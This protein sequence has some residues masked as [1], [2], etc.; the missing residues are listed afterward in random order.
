MPTALSLTERRSLNK[1]SQPLLNIDS[2]DPNQPAPN[3]RELKMLM[4]LLRKVRFSPQSRRDPRDY[5]FVDDT[6]LHIYNTIEVH[7]CD[8]PDRQIPVYLTPN[9]KILRESNTINEQPVSCNLRLCELLDEVLRRVD[10]ILIILRSRMDHSYYPFDILMKKLRELL[11]LLDYS[12][13]EMAHRG[14]RPLHWLIDLI[15]HLHHTLNILNSGR[16]I[17]EY[18]LERFLHHLSHLYEEL[19]S[20][21]REL[22]CEEIDLSHRVK[23]ADVEDDNDKTIEDIATDPNRKRILET[24]TVLGQYVRPIDGTPPRIE[25]DMRK[26]N[27]LAIRDNV[28]LYYVIEVVFFHEM[29]HAL[30]DRFPYT[31]TDQYIREIDEPI[32][33]YGMLCIMSKQKDAM[34]MDYAEKFVYNK[35]FNGPYCYSLGWE[36]FTHIDKINAIKRR[37]SA[38]TLLAYYKNALNINR[39]SYRLA[40]YRDSFRLGF[41]QGHDLTLCLKRLMLLIGHPDY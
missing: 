23:D 25:L 13:H 41:P 29:I 7:I 3:C 34:L 28:P 39:N 16:P 1:V 6:L 5:C 11:N 9:E 24:M 18:E 36:L 26:I 2:I 31:N 12:I 14:S 20:L 21:K 30:L 27:D 19:V 22:C 33:E 10:E 15:E 37:G 8:I 35:R 4:N 40:A 32:A 17:D 38:K